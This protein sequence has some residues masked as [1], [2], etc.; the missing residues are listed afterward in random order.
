MSIFR[1]E[2]LEHQCVRLSGT[3]YLKADRSTGRAAFV[4][5]VLALLSMVGF[6]AMEVDGSVPLSCRVDTAQ[7]A[8]VGPMA[9]RTGAGVRIE[10]VEIVANGRV[11]VLDPQ[12]RAANGD[13]ERIVPLTPGTT[14][15]RCV[16]TARLALRPAQLI[17][18][19]LAK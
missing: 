9:L 19:K 3:V 15:G 11:H 4:F 7:Q 6:A 13:G 8:F 18:A 17:V 12:I 5:I 1:K 16:A 2:A 10:R 14:A